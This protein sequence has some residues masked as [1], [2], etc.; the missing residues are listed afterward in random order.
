MIANDIISISV[1]QPVVL[2]IDGEVSGGRIF[3]AGYVIAVVNSNFLEVR[4]DGDQ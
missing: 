3:K 2:A 1:I 4:Q